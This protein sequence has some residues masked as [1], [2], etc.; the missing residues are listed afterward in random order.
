MD[1]QQQQCTAWYRNEFLPEIKMLWRDGIV[2]VTLV[3]LKVA[4][5]H[6]KCQTRL[7]S[8]LS[9]STQDE[10]LVIIYLHSKRGQSRSVHSTCSLSHIFYSLPPL[11]VFHVSNSK[12]CLEKFRWSESNNSDKI[13]RHH[14]NTT[15]LRERLI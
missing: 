10:L 2:V 4:I 3:L 6:I 7:V 12:R 11:S 14:G 5:L 13:I 1:H 9:A 8:I 15:N